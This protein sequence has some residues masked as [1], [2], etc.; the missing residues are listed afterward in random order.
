MNTKIEKRK[1]NK[2]RTVADSVFQKKNKGKQSLGFMDNRPES[3]V[4]RLLQKNA[5]PGTQSIQL[6]SQVI[7]LHKGTNQYDVTQDDMIIYKV[8]LKFDGSVVYVGQTEA[9]VGI[10]G[11]F[12][13][14]LLTHTTWKESTH[15]IERIE[16]GSWTRFETDCSEQYWIDSFGGKDKL[17][18]EKN[19]VSKERFTAVCKHQEDKSLILFRGEGI[20]FPKGWKPLN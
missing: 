10:K 18:N 12:A 9:T 14:H 5:M 2:N 6:Q 13:Q 3:I 17:E 1:E 4:Q 8:V 16:S 7:Q 19:Q 20:G 11:R 15:K